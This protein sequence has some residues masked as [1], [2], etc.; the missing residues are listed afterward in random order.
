MKKLR[1]RP[2]IEMRRTK[3][4]QTRSMIAPNNGAEKNWAPPYEASNAPYQYAW[5]GLSAVMLETSAG[6]TGMTMPNPSMSRNTVARIKGRPAFR[7]C[8]INVLESGGSRK[9]T[10]NEREEKAQP[11][12]NAD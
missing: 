3:R 5:A 12:M 4:R 2:K 10:A 7:R 9:R 1:A 8:S 6:N 11:Q